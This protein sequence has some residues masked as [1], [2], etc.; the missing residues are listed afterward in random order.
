MADGQFAARL[1]GRSPFSKEASHSHG[2]KTVGW[3]YPET[4]VGWYRR[5]F[6]IPE[7]DLGKHISV[8]FD[9]IF[10]DAQVFCN[11]FYL[12]HEPS[13]YA[14]QVYDLTEYLNYGGENLL[15]VRVD[16]STEEG[17]FY[18][19]AGIYRDVWLDKMSQ[20]HVVPFG[21]FV[22]THIDPSYK[23]ADVNIEIRL[24]N[25]GLEAADCK[26]VNRILDETG[27]EVV[28]T[29]ESSTTLAPKQEEVKLLQSATMD[30]IQ[31]WDLEHPYLYTLYTDVYVGEKLVDT[32]TTNFGLR[33]IEFNPQKGFL[34]NGCPVKLKGTNLH[35][36]HAGVGTGIP[37]RLWKYRI[38][39]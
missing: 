18:E 23:T 5:K 39:K 1:G 17:W 16:A 33:N 38:E 31:L 6:Y 34:L 19:G 21:T 14:T 12:G 27:K 10:R 24:A 32:Y 3:K 25:K 13:G 2:Y 7:G 28:R 11:G 35:Q 8:R 26:V 36:D 29:Q 20:V 9:G 30:N 22:A 4:S 37:D 15:T